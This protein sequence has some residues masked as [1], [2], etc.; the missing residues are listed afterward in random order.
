[1][2]FDFYA[3]AVLVTLHGQIVEVFYATIA[4][5]WMHINIVDCFVQEA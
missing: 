3:T 5:G 4:A 1:V 2:L